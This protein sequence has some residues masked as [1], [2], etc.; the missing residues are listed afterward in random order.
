M[1]VAGIGGMK[2][3][4]PIHAQTL[5]RSMDIAEAFV[6]EKLIYLLAGIGVV[7]VLAT[8]AWAILR[9]AQ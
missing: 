3:T 6:R 4:L 7:V 2:I 8:V 1:V 5:R 9:L